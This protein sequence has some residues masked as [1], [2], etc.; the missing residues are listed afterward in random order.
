MTSSEPARHD[1]T[2]QC[3]LTLIGTLTRR[4]ATSRLQS[5]R[6]AASCPA[7]LPSNPS[8]RK[9]RIRRLAD[10]DSGSDVGHDDPV[11]KMY[12]AADSPFLTQKLAQVNGVGQVF[13]GGASAA[14]GAGRS[15]S[16]IAEQ[17]LA[18]ALDTVK[19]ALSAANANTTKGER[20]GQVPTY[21]QFLRVRPVFTADQ[22][23]PADRGV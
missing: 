16:N 12:D 4:R 20:F 15:E 13:V 11:P 18:L 17:A 5:M 9:D 14:G 23:Q 2:S 3:N 19:N 7:N 21:S 6:R 8:Y 1:R 22:Y 10:P